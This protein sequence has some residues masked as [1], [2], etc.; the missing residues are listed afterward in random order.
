MKIKKWYPDKNIFERICVHMNYLFSGYRGSVTRDCYLYYGMDTLGRK[1]RREMLMD[2]ELLKFE[3]ILNSDEERIIFNSKKVFYD[4]F[5]KYMKRDVLLVG[6]SSYFEFEAFAHNRDIIIKPDNMYGG[7]GVML[8][9]NNASKKLYLKQIYDTAHK[10]GSIAEERLYNHEAYRNIYDRSLNTIRV[11][12][13]I[14]KTGNVEILGCINQFGSNGS[15][16]DNDENDGIWAVANIENGIVTDCEKCD[17]TAVIYDI[18]PDTGRSIIGFENVSW[19]KV[20]GMAREAAM[21]VPQCRLIGWDIAV[22][23]N[24]DVE[25]IEGNV[26][27]ELG[28]FEAISHKGLRS[29]LEQAL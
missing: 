13:L 23:E 18:H 10:A 16:T 6:D 14:N 17:E 19:N 22:L 29:R 25:L 8:I 15:I 12:T 27:P 9:E 28:V 7:Q 2:D 26:T 24:G 21:V 3:R 1:E 11:I 5:G 20:L 4:K